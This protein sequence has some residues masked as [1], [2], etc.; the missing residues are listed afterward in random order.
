LVNVD[1]GSERVPRQRSASDQKASVPDDAD[2]ILEDSSYLTWASSG[3]WTDSSIHST[4]ESVPLTILTLRKTLDNEKKA[5]NVTLAKVRSG[6][7][8]FLIAI[9]GTIAI[10]IA[11]AVSQADNSRSVLLIVGTCFLGVSAIAIGVLSSARRGI[12]RDKLDIDLTQ[13]VLR[14]EIQYHD[15]LAEASRLHDA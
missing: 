12:R 11:F 2:E 7:V 3:L 8:T 6:T 1:D 4:P 5:Q 10:S 14:H 9:S 13:N 15:R